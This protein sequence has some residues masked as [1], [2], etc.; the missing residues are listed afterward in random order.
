[1]SR[2]KLRN[3]SFDRIRWG[4]EGNY[5]HIACFYIDLKYY[6]PS[7][8]WGLFCRVKEITHFRRL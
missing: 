6:F 7:N 1:M 5:G 3:S 2:K 8:E 4:T